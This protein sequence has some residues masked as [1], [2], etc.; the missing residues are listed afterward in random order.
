MTHTSVRNL[1]V[2]RLTSAMKSLGVFADPSQFR[3]EIPEPQFGEFSS[4]IA[5]IFAKTLK[6]S[7]KALAEELSSIMAKDPMF[8]SVRI[9]GPGFLNMKLHESIYRDFLRELIFGAPFQWN[10]SQQRRKIQLEFVSANPTGPLTVGHGRQAILGDVLSKVMEKAGVHVTKEYYFNDSGKQMKLL[11]RSFW[12][13]YNEVFGVIHEIPE[14]GYHGK[15]LL[16]MAESF[17]GKIGAEYVDRWDT[18]IETFFLKEAK[19]RMFEVIQETL[20]L[21]HIHFDVFTSEGE[22]F[23]SGLVQKVFDRLKEADMVYEKD[24]A[25]W[26]KVSRFADEDDKVLIR[27]DGTPTY[28]FTDIAYHYQ[29]FLRDFNQVFDIWGADHHGHIPRMKAALRALDIPDDFFHVILHQMVSLRK[30]GE[31][32]KMSTRSGEFFTLDELLD[33]VGLDA[34]RFFY[35]MVDKDAQMVFDIDLAKK[36]TNDNPVFYVQYAYARICRLMEHAQEKGVALSL[37]KNLDRLNGDA[38]HMLIRDMMLFPEVIEET[39]RLLSPHKICGYVVALV[40]KFHQY[41]TDH[42]FVDPSE[43]DRSN[44]RLQLAWAVKKM[45]AECLTL[46]GVSTPER[47]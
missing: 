24:G 2:S 17:A 12:V 10:K 1:I 38:E 34:L 3:V 29:K 14:G 26:L 25:V 23:T 13:R 19:E 36:Q 47:M 41:Y 6:R 37:G 27:S 4:N 42:V 16:T 28:F 31:M 21:L 30:E 35:A 43:M 5:M 8:A 39:I 46:L 15:Y 40:T 44:A 20:N 18:S 33:E 11:A 32:V 9:D 45:I 7:P 22:L